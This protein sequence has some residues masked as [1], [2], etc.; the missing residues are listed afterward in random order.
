[1]YK[2]EIAAVA[3]LELAEAHDWYEQEEPGLGAELLAEFAIVRKRVLGRPLSFPRVDV[4]TRRALL[5]RFPYGVYF[6][7]EEDVVSVTAFFHGRR[8]PDRRIGR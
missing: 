8:D 5:K 1:V 2:L 4:D 7:V 6:V 3:A